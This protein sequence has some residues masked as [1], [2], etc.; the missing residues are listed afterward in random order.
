MSNADVTKRPQDLRGGIFSNTPGKIE[1]WKSDTASVVLDFSA[2]TTNIV[3]AYS[4]TGEPTFTELDVNGN[5][6]QDV[7]LTAAGDGLNS[8]L[9][10]NSTTAAVEGLDITVAQLTTPRSSG[11]VDG[12]KVSLTSLAGD[13][14]GTYNDVELNCTD[15]GG[16]AVHQAIKLGA[17]FDVALD[18]SACATGEAD[19][20]MGDNL[21]SAFQFREGANIYLTLV[22]TNGAE[23]VRI[24]KPIDCAAA[25]SSI[26]MIDNSGTAF[27]FKE[28]ATSYMI[29]STAN[30]VEKIQ[31]TKTVELDTI[32]ERVGDQ[33]V[34]IDGLQIK[35]G[36][37][38]SNTFV[39]VAM[40]ITGG[41]GGST[42]G[43]FD[44]DVKTMAGINVTAAKCVKILATTSGNAG[45]GAQALVSTVTFTNATLGSIVT[46]GNGYA[47]VLTD[48]TGNF[49]CTVADSADETVAFSATTVDGGVA[50]AGQGCLVV[51]SVRATGTWSA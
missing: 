25:A 7:A 29:F 51:E 11:T 3:I 2:V 39:K 16:S 21:A 5:I 48:S 8:S 22:T 28:G 49:A 10:I 36:E 38:V 23:A 13:S 30:G 17:G 9:T 43:T 19:V 45:K 37:P 31:I 18:A 1:V 27:A 41:T 33:G 32:N 47:I 34:V 50:S 15:G 44:L 26:S 4:A 40:A 46:S 12:I 35:D 6:D 20:V 14:G 42:D 24:D